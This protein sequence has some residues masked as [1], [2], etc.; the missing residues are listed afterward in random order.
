MLILHSQYNDCWWPGDA[1]SQ[2]IIRHWVDSVILEYSYLSTRRVPDSTVHGANM[3]PTWV[4]LTPDGPHDGPMN[5]AIKGWSLLS[6][7]PISHW[8]TLMEIQLLFKY[9][10][11]IFYTILHHVGPCYSGTPL[12]VLD[13]SWYP[14]HKGFMSWQSKSGKYPSCSFLK[15]FDLIR[16]QFCTCHDSLAVMACTNL[17]SDWMIKIIITTKNIYERFQ[18]WAH[19]PFVKWIPGQRVISLISCH[20]EFEFSENIFFHFRSFN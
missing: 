5:L 4:L 12:I 13:E 17:W 7:K 16:S 2:G 15:T 10:F 19:K 8:M 11:Y 14:S 18:L 6:F 1:R 3:G 20:L 9:I